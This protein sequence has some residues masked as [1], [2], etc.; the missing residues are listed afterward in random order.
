MLH[1]KQ[2]NINM[3]VYVFFSLGITL[4]LLLLRAVFLSMLSQL[5]ILRLMVAVPLFPRRDTLEVDF[6]SA[7]I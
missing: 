1:G 6:L 4:H 3:N 2:Y 5:E 7:V